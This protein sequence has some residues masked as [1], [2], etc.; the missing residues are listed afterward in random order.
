[1]S[2]DSVRELYNDLVIDHSRNS[3]FEGELASATYQ[4][5]AFNSLCGD[6]IKL[7]FAIDDANRI[8]SIRWTAPEGACIFSRAS[9]SM[10]ASAVEGKTLHEVRSLLATLRQFVRGMPLASTELGDFRSLEG[11]VRLP[12][13]TKCVAL[14]WMA[15]ESALDEHARSDEAGYSQSEER[16]GMR[17]GRIV[18]PR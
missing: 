18:P 10:L 11:V 9:A 7:W 2:D 4:P 17:I 13:R 16:A 1:M 8:S 5:E 3:E 12:M 6:H 14:S 15:L